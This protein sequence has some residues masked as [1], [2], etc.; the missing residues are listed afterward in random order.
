MADSQI[1]TREQLKNNTSPKVKMNVHY[2]TSILNCRDEQ[3]KLLE[4]I[5]KETKLS[6]NLDITLMRTRETL[7]KERI[8][9]ETARDNFKALQAKQAELQS[10]LDTL[11]ESRRDNENLINAQRIQNDKIQENIV[12]L[13]LKIQEAGVELSN[14]QNIYFE[15]VTKEEHLNKT[16]ENLHEELCNR[17]FIV[18]TTRE[19]NEN[20]LHN[21]DLL[22]TEI[23]SLQ[24]HLSV[25]QKEYEDL[26]KQLDD[27]LFAGKNLQNR[28]MKTKEE[29]QNTSKEKE[30]LS[31]NLQNAN[32]LYAKETQSNS[33][34]QKELNQL[35]SNI[36]HLGNE[37]FKTEELLKRSTQTKQVLL[38][39]IQNKHVHIENI[40]KKI[41]DKKREISSQETNIG[42]LQEELKSLKL[43]LYELISEQS[44]LDEQTLLNTNIE[45]S[46]TE[47]IKKAKKA[48]QESSNTLKENKQ[49][50]SLIRKPPEQTN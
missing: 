12:S 50:L 6:N 23:T 33:E 21:L 4:K 40:Q 10:Q 48:V 41:E 38:T 7:L 17:G 27:M 9:L 35:N 8:T 31:K 1:T 34:L 3:E 19:K 20:Q 30:I 28:I 25:A 47:Q 22:Q 26:K 29:I 5:E 36:E 18:V 46:K 45:K 32:E 11:S 42:T 49:T 16:V 13:S 39:N 2:R 15:N 24:Q 43:A 44:D 37:L 14:L